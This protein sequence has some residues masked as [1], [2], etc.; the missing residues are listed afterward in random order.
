MAFSAIV[1]KVLAVLV[2][3]IFL[4]QGVYHSTGVDVTPRLSGIKF[5]QLGFGGSSSSSMQED[6]YFFRP[7][8]V[9]FLDNGGGI[10]KASLRG[11]DA[12]VVYDCS[13]GSINP[14]CSQVELPV[15]PQQPGLSGES[16][17]GLVVWEEDWGTTWRSWGQS[18]DSGGTLNSMFT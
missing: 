9:P 8:F 5:P 18:F 4:Q 2:G 6:E 3:L 12:D 7:P 14:S 15:D 16:L 11:T 13:S 17:W 1:I 10:Q